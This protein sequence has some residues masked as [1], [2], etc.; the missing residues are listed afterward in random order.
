MRDVTMLPPV[1][2]ALREQRKVTMGK[3]E[4]VF[5]NQYH[6]PLLPDS[7]SQHVW[8]VTLSKAGLE[9]RRMYKTRH[10]FAT[11]MLDAGELPGWVQRMM[12]HETLQMIHERY[13]SYIKNYQRDDGKAFM[14][15]V[16]NTSK[17]KKIEERDEKVAIDD[18]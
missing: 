7:M 15:N 2:E 6:R 4:Y 13:Y 9:D 8:K 16:Y 18:K 1:V 17:D 14:E 11:L 12:G 3:L 10:T 5:F